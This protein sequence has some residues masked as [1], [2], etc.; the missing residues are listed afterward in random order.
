MDTILLAQ[1]DGNTWQRIDVF[2]DIPITLTIQQNDLTDLTSR[3][4]PYSKTIQIPDTNNNAIL[5]EH[6]YEVNGIEFNP[7]QK[8]PCVVQYRG[9]DIFQG[10]MRM[11]SVTTNSEERLYEI[12]LMGEVSDFTAPLRNLQLQDLNYTDLNHDLVYSSVTTS[13]EC[14][15]DGNSGLF[16]GQILYPLI[17]YGL[18]YQGNTSSAATSTF[19]YDFDRPLSFDQ[20]SRSVPPSIFKPAIQVKSVLD[21]MFA[22]TG[23][24]VISEF[25]DSPYFTSIYMDTFQNG[26]IGVEY[27]SGVTNQNIFR[28]YMAPLTFRYDKDD[29]HLLP[30]RDFIG[31]AYDPLNNFAN[32]SGSNRFKV[33]YAGQ[34]GFN[35]RFN[36]LTTDF[37]F[38]YP[39][40]IQNAKI[41]VQAWK[42]T[43][44]TDIVGT[45]T[46]F[47]ESPEIELKQAFRDGNIGQGPLPVNLFFNDNFVAGEYIT[48]VIFDKTTYIPLCGSFGQGAKQYRIQAYDDG[49]IIDPFPLYELY[50]SPTIITELVDMTLG[51]PNLECIDFLKSMITMFNL[52]IT[53]DE[54]EKTLRIEPYN[55]DY[56]DPTRTVRD[57]TKILDLNSDVKVEPL[58]FELAKDGIWT[59]QWTDNEYLPK[60]WYDQYN[61]V[62]GR[63]RFTSDSNFFTGEKIYET[64]FGSCPTSGVTNAPNFII[65]QFYYLNNGQQTPYATKPHLF[66]WV[67]NRLAWKDQFKTQ[68]GSWYLTSGSTPIEWT[69][70]PCVSHLSTLESQISEV[71]SDLNFRSTFDFFGNSNTQIQQF[72]DYNVYNVFWETYVDNLYDPTGKRLTGNFYFRPID[73]YETKLNDKIWIKDAWYTIEKMTDADLVNKRL[74]QISLIKNN[75]PYYKV[76]PPAPIYIYA[77]N[78]GYPGPT[79]FYYDLAYISTDKDSVCDESATQFTYYSDNN[80]LTIENYDV[81]YLDLTGPTLLPMGTYIKQQGSTTTFVCVDTYG[82]VLQTSC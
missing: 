27:A 22:E 63:E 14:V 79:Q 28:T 15:N 8:I 44:S 54:Q 40:N 20:S 48:V 42:S 75:T 17:N 45:G 7:L 11:N 10:I 55:W 46:M 61:F 50:Q 72:T 66:F 71:I 82:R 39:L 43:S 70:Y 31:P 65:P 77:P 32:I 76:E 29:T 51:M 62:Y 24:E 68:Q 59:N 58:S 57:W 9:T 26:K 33:P 34:Y 73:V 41:T 19:T 60:L 37:C 81:I 53:Q 2:E 21:R 23:Y 78:E 18:D 13:W 1:L 25:F 47:Y 64:P 49:T 80:S 30:F 12:Y 3:R 74:T 69:T 38:A 36:V 52:I 16:N 67:G 5:F 4:V 35:I 6:Y 56:N